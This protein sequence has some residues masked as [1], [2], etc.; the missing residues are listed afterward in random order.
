[1]ALPDL[2]S[3]VCPPGAPVTAEWLNEPS[4]FALDF[5]RDFSRAHR[6]EDGEHLHPVPD[7]AGLIEWDGSKYTIAPGSRN[8]ES[9]SRTA[10][11]D[12][13]VELK[14]AAASADEW[15]AMAFPHG[16]AG[17]C[18]EVISGSRPASVCRIRLTEITYLFVPP[19]EPTPGQYDRDG[20]FRF[21]AYMEARQPGSV[22]DAPALEPTHAVPH[23]VC[24]DGVES[25]AHRNAL[26]RFCDW[27][28]ATWATDHQADGDGT[29]RRISAPGLMPIGCVLAR[30]DEIVWATPGAFE[31]L[32]ARDG[33][34]R[35]TTTQPIRWAHHM[36]RVS[37]G[38]SGYPHGVSSYRFRRDGDR[39]GIIDPASANSRI[40]ADGW[41][42]IVVWG[43]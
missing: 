12:V 26:Y 10:T 41:I 5:Q 4:L 30:R 36:L 14:V 40:P 22:G 28:R 8:I 6:P 16:W 7:A 2:S 18:Y 25:A 17:R 11:G 32:E 1:M 31:E 19:D 15:I 34:V 27:A 3:L 29:H 33:A 20:S 9:V 39:R 21:E 35:F 42:G 43:R 38:S 13:L 23:R 24:V 37:L